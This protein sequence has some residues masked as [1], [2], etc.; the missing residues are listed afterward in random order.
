VAGTGLSR[1][2]RKTW[3]SQA[4]ISVIRRYGNGNIRIVGGET[5]HLIFIADMKYSLGREGFEPS[6]VAVR[7]PGL[8]YLVLGEKLNDNIQSELEI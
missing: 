6:P 3:L 7:S 8:Y 2:P 1:K 4:F 5:Y